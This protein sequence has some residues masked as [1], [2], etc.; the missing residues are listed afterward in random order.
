[1]GSSSVN[2]YLCVRVS[3]PAAALCRALCLLI[4]SATHA[5]IFPSTCS[6]LSNI[7]PSNFSLNGCMPF[8]FCWFDDSCQL[9]CQERTGVLLLVGFAIH[10]ILSHIFMYPKK[11]LSAAVKT[12]GGD[13]LLFITAVWNH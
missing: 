10:S 4:S 1:M 6:I 12:P 11:P 3:L 13:M 5:S 7:Y 8:L 2:P 9:H